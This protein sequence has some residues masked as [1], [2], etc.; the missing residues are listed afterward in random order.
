MLEKREN[1]R[2]VYLK[3]YKSINAELVRKNARLN[4]ERVKSNKQTELD[5]AKDRAK[6]QREYE[7]VMQ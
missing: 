4:E 3:D 5:I 7:F 1:T 2:D 6:R